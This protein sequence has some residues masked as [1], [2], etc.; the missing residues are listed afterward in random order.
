MFTRWI[1][2]GAF[3]AVFRNHDAGASAGGCNDN[4]P[5]SCS[6]VRPWN[7]PLKFFE[8]NRLA[9]QR[10]AALV[11]YHY[12][13]ARIAFDS[14]LGPL[15][16]MYIDWPTFSEAYSF[17]G[18][19]M[20]GDDMLV[21]P[22]AAPVSPINNMV[23]WA[24]WLPPGE[25]IEYDTGAV[26]P[27]NQILNK[28]FDLS[29]IPVFVRAGAVIPSLPFPD[30]PGGSGQVLAQAR[31]PYST[32]VFNIYPTT[33]NSS[34]FKAVG[35]V[36]EDDGIS[37][38]YLQGRSAVTTATVTWLTPSQVQVDIVTV[39]SYPGLPAARVYELRFVNQPAPTSVVASGRALPFSRFGSLN[40]WSY[41]GVSVSAVV[42]ASGVST[43]SGAVFTVSA[44]FL[45]LDSLSGLRGAIAHAKLCKDN[46][47]EVRVNV[48]DIESLTDMASAGWS[49][50][51]LAGADQNAFAS[52]VKSL[53]V[54]FAAALFE[55]QQ[56]NVAPIDP[57]SL[58]LHWSPSRRDS[59]LCGT[60]GCRESNNDDA[61]YGFV[62]VEGFMPPASAAGVVSLRDFWN[63]N[64][65]DNYATTQSSPPSGY[66]PADFPNGQVFA[67]SQPGTV[68]LAVYYNDQFADYLTVASA[69]GHQFAQVCFFFACL[70][71]MSN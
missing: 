17:Q 49:L 63:A 21:S 37:L 69:F 14:G 20:L 15:R 61:G 16:P 2:W 36:Y 26:L 6:V 30:A 25:W 58:T 10:R 31:E 24:V 41:D 71:L 23:E 5:P 11:P 57:T 67:S 56:L 12:T 45:Q 27:G 22:I 7:V 9:M 50:G 8:I 32:L 43:K 53:S 65:E 60:D 55:A 18:Q 42:R 1:Q 33:G 40:A 3:S 38:D 35:T 39:G 70:L 62:S 29:E 54:T 52:L 68:P 13:L 28:S 34:Q 66:T 44:S 47:D 4:N 51:Y 59:V 64:I 46:L 48:N 19:Y